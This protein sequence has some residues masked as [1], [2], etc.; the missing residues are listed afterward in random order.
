MFENLVA[1]VVGSSRGIGKEIAIRMAEYGANIVVTYHY[2][3]DKAIETCDY[4]RKIG[5]MVLPLNIDLSEDESIKTFFNHIDNYFGHIDILVN[6]AG[7]GIPKD[8]ES[9][10]LEDWN[11]TLNINLT[12]PFLCTKYSLP[13]FK[14]VNG[15]RIINVSSVAGL[16]GG[17]FGPH[18]GATKAGIIGLTKS[19]ARELAKYNILVNAVAPGPIQSEMTN[20]LSEKIISQIVENTPMKRI[21]QNIEVAEFVCQLANPKINYITGQTIVID[22]GRYMI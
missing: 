11:K 5:R 8:I 16:T 9:I 19:T 20:S 2:S 17:S 6:N 4:I 18:Y 7:I 1:V 12:G 3:K 14:K 10:S 13:L 15:G 22:G 21:G